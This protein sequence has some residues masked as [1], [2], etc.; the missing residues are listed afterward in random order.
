MQQ[1]GSLSTLAVPGHPIRSAE[2]NWQTIATYFILKIT[3]QAL[4]EECNRIA[5]EAENSEKARWLKSKVV[6]L[7]ID[8]STGVIDEEEYGIR[9]AEILDE[10]GKLSGGSP[11]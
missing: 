10:L 11:K 2:V 3:F 8:F 7:D 1:R 6:Q 9:Q 5:N 4:L